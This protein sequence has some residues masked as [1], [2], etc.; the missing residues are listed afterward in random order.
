[1]LCRTIYLV[2]LLLRV[3]GLHAY[4]DSRLNS[5]RDVLVVVGNFSIDGQLANIAQYEISTAKYVY[6][7]HVIMSW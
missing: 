1:M 4:F 5:G 6:L 2:V 3:V 7:C